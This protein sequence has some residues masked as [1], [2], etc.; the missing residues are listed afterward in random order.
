MQGLLVAG[1]VLLSL[2]SVLQWIRTKERVTGVLAGALGLLTLVIVLGQIDEMTDGRYEDVIGFFS[3]FGFLL[4]GYLLLVFR[5]EFI[6]INTFALR[7]I[8]GLVVTVGVLNLLF[9]APQNQDAYTTRD[10]VFVYSALLVWAGCVGEPAVRFWFAARG[11]PVVQR[12]RLRSLSGAYASLILLILLAVVGTTGGENPTVDV[13]INTVALSLVPIFYASVSPPRWLRSIWRGREEESVRITEEL[14][15]YAPDVVT[16][17]QRVVANAVRLVGADAGFV[18]GQGG[19]ILAHTGISPEEALALATTVEPHEVGRHVKALGDTLHNF[20]LLPLASDENPDVL[21][22]VLGPFTPL[23]GSDELARLKDFAALSGVAIDRVRLVEAVGRESERY[24]ALLQAVS[25]VGEGFV[26]VEGGACVWANEAYCKM[27]G[28]S[29]EELQALPSL[30][31]LSRPEDRAE[32]TQRMRERLAGEDVSSHY[33][34]ALL[35]KDG[36]VRW[37]EVAIKMLDTLEGRRVVSLVRDISERKE[38]ERS[39]T[40]QTATLQLLQRIAETANEAQDLDDVLR[41]AVQEVCS[42]TGWPVGHVYLPADD[43]ADELVPADIWCIEAEDRF[44][45]FKRVTDETRIPKE[46]GFPADVLETGRPEWISDLLDDVPSPR[47]EAA[48][49]CNIHTA[50]AFPVLA[51]QEVAGVLEF[52]TEDVL[53]PD[54]DMLDVMSNIGTQLG[55]VAER[56]RIERFRNDFISNAAHELR[57][58]VTPIVGY[59]SLLADRWSEMSEADRQMMTRTL[60]QQGNRLR[61]LVNSLLDFT[62]V[63]RGRLQIDLESVNLNDVFESVMQAAPPPEGKSVQVGETDGTVVFA[64]KAR[65]EDM[66]VNL[67]VNAYRYGGARIKLEGGLAEDGFHVW[68]ADNGDGVQPELVPDLFDP[69]TRGKGSADIGGSGLGL[70]IVRM[71]AKAQGGDVWYEHEDGE[72]RFVVKLRPPPAA[73]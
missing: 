1:F 26:I 19:L 67:L 66:L 68:V 3:L 45:E 22:V 60:R 18:R 73:V 63:Q 21:G 30:L 70:A 46:A 6:P 12:A 47:T 8:L 48:R 31:D 38:A 39:L 40:E 71:L 35:T 41:V 20:V 55:R 14:A 50:M 29:L 62:R 37:V 2:S 44:A 54:L 42:Y 61:T 43:L 51:G 33:E 15:S 28:Y 57:T 9:P 53:E 69:F 11:R 65:L 52:F 5:H 25:D 24:E 16:V 72:P 59:S 23:F 36:Q 34:S 32:L 49:V 10:F 58:P 17:A 4:S 64:D 13:A 56:K 7:L 27:T